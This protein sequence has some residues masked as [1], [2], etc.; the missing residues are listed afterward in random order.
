LPHIAVAAIAGDFRGGVLGVAEK[1]EVGQHIHWFR[2]S[3]SRVHRG[4]A[5]LAFRRGRE[6]RALA[7]F[8]RGVAVDTLQLQRGVTLMTEAV[9]C[10]TRYGN[11]NATSESE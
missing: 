8:G 6:C 9:R 10:K 2:W 3:Y 7:G 11:E 5:G 1:D 4:M